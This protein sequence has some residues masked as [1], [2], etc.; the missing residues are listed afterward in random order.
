MDRFQQLREEHVEQ[1]K[2][3][4][5]IGIQL[6]KIKKIGETIGT[7]LSD[8]D[9]IITDIDRSTDTVGVKLDNAN[10]GIAHIL[11]NTSTKWYWIV[12]TLV[13]IAVVLLVVVIVI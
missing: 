6:G 5:A 9:K 3:L 10:N 1:D 7:E 4:D 11:K 2:S 13:V 12:G 8:Q